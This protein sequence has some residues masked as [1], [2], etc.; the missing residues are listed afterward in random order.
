M[1]TKYQSYQSL[2]RLL[3]D[4]EN[5]ICDDAQTLNIWSR[6]LGMSQNGNA[7]I[8]YQLSRYS[9]LHGNHTLFEELKRNGFH[10]ISPNLYTEDMVRIIK[11]KQHGIMRK[12]DLELTAEEII[13][14]LIY[15][16]RYLICSVISTVCN[17]E[18]F[19]K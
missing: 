3:K 4:K 18:H 6:L 15:T 16:G 12:Y 17:S 2:L 1:T 13:S 14:I 11:S 9:C 5:I 8:L 7:F 19:P 10:T